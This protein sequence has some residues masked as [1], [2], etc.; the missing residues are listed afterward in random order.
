M[1]YSIAEELALQG[2][3]VILVSGPTNLEIKNPAISIVNVIKI[4]FNNFH[5]YSNMLLNMTNNVF[6]KT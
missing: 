2:A 5:S 6:S 3:Q 1:G 4:I